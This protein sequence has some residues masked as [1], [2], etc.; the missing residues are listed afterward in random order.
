LIVIGAFAAVVASAA[1]FGFVVYN[2]ATAIDRSTPT[3]VAEQFLGASLIDRD[4]GR[5]SLFVCDSWPATDALA[6]TTMPPGAS[7]SWDEFT[8]VPEDDGAIVSVN[9]R[10][11]IDQESVTHFGIESWRIRLEERDGWRVCSVE[12]S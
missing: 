4:A 2:R 9:V 7:V 3:V 6:A 10:F 12:R 11:S 1:I 5:V 8:V